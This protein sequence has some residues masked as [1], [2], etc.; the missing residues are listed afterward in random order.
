MRSF[1]I[2]KI[3]MYT[4]IKVLKNSFTK[5]KIGVILDL[6]FIILELILNYKP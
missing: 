2:I 1:S 5:N 6:A 3:F 4:K